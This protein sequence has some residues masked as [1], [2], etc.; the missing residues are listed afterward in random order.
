MWTTRGSSR[1]PRSTPL[2]SAVLRVYRIP[3]S[4]NVER[5][6]LA[7]AYKGL[8]LDWIDVDPRDRSFVVEASGQ[9]LVPVLDHDGR[10]VF[11][12][13]AIL[14]YLDELQ[15]EPKLFRTPEIELFVDWFNRVWKV[16]PNAIDAERRAAAPDEDRIA[17]HGTEM[18]VSL[19]LID[20]LLSGR[21]FLFGD[22]SAADCAAFPFLKYAVDH[23]P[24]DD[25]PF[26][27]ILREFLV[28][29]GHARLRGWIGRVDALP[30]A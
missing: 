15:P 24:D 18:T 3:F 12:S 21:D 11:D 6:A 16:P 27:E 29:D 10:I 14:F 8:A 7:A 25:E 5:V 17:Q 23:T 22:F 13:T 26:H 2:N 19:D 28:L 30:R 9:E 1:R 20:R 4:T